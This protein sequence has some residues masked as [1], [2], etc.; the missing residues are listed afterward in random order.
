MQEPK[1]TSTTWPMMIAATVVLG[2]CS[3]TPES[4]PPPQASKPSITIKGFSTPESVLHDVARDVYY[5]SSINGAPTAKDDNGFISKVSPTG[6]VL[7]LKFIDGATDSVTL[8]APKGMGLVGDR[9]IVADIDVIRSFDVTTGALLD[10]L[11]VHGAAFLNDVATDGTTVVISDSGLGDGGAH[12]TL[13]GSDALY[14][15]DLRNNA[16]TKIVQGTEVLSR[17]NGLAIVDGSVYVACLGAPHINRFDLQGAALGQWSLPAGSLDGLVSDGA[18]GF[19]VSSW[20]SQSIY[21]VSETGE[22]TVVKQGLT[23]PADIALDARRKVLLVPRFMDNV[24]EVH[25]L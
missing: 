19:Y 7:A 14:V 5:V 13:S 11:P 15:L 9:L 21:A 2:S 1:R 12:G 16:L 25:P 4:P 17:A 18:G 24:V 23:A 6:E 22:A 10:E 20:E 8:H 3:T